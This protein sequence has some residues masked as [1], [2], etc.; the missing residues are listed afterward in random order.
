MSHREIFD[1]PRIRKM[2]NRDYVTGAMLHLGVIM[3]GMSPAIDTF[4]VG[5]CFLAL[6]RRENKGLRGVEMIHRLADELAP[7]VGVFPTP[8]ITI[9]VDHGSRLHR[10]RWKFGRAA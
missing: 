3:P 2:T 4:N 10:K 6:L 8:K 5:C 7:A 1:G 9:R